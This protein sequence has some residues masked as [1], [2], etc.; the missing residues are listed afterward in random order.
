[1][2]L[3]NIS[4]RVLCKGCI[5][6]KKIVAIIIIAVMIITI[7][8]C[9]KNSSL[10]KLSDDCGI[11][12]SV[13]KIISEEDNHGGFQG[14][15]FSLL[16]ADYSEDASVS[17]EFSASEY[18]HQMP[19]PDSLNTFAYQ[20]YDEALEIPQIVNG[21]YYFYDRHSES[22]DPYDASELLNRYSFNFTFAIYDLDTNTL[23]LCKY[24]T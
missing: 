17:D 15:G 22:T 14:D 8:G 19:L 6:F 4:K 7:N 11:D 10:K 12:L 2:R 1:M 13:G 23:Y 5:V 3:H 18:W 24:D 9:G 20:P 21:Y 16:V